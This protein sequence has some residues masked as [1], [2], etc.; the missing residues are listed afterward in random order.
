MTDVFIML[1]AMKNMQ[2]ALRKRLASKHMAQLGIGAFLVQSM[3]QYVQYPNSLTGYVRWHVLFVKLSPQ[4]DKAKLFATKKK[5]L[6][7]LDDKLNQLGYDY[8]LQ[9]IR[10]K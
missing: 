2:S 8:V 4:E 7:S 9:D 1:V 6:K 3:K 5:I 10:L